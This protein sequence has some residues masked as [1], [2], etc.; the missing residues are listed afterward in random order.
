M[1][2]KARQYELQN[3]SARLKGDGFIRP[4]SGGIDVLG[5]HMSAVQ[6]AG[7]AT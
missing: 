7:F 1:G 2:E 3:G 6:K 5:S 4:D